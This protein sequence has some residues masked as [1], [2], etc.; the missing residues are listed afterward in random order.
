MTPPM[1]G[2]EGACAAPSRARY[3]VLPVPYEGTV[4]YL[5]GTAGAPEAILAASEQVELFDEE[6]LRECHHAGIATLPPV[7]PA[8][9]PA[10]QMQRVRAAAAP[11]VEAG[12]FVLALGGEHSITAPLVAAVAE[13]RRGVSVL[14]VDAHA[15]LRDEYDGTRHSHA[16]VMRRVLEVT[17]R[18]CQVGVRSFS[19]AE[20]AEC[21]E[22]I[23]ALVTPADMDSA[24][25]WIG[26]VVERLADPVY[27]TIDLDGL[28][29]SIAPGIGT[30]EPGGL[31]WRQVTRLLRA[32][33]REREVV[34]ADIV[35][36]V[37]MPP[38]T[39]TEF[40]AARLAYKIVAY[41][42]E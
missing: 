29:P 13:A 21:R 38:A 1:L 39:L 12:K 14:Q 41:T 3:V 28:D 42:Q 18:V 36:A 16:C 34:G 32:V 2:E 19:A 4:S 24:D 23:D 31:T 35:E 22:R 6:L 15:D 25:A 27:V 33:C 10:E 7:A 30:P 20:Y 11:W 40:T 37:P 17:D 9:A 26:R 5:T 8:D